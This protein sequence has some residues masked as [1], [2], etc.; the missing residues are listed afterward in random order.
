MQGDLQSIM[1][2]KISQTKKG[3]EVYDFIRM[4]DIKQKEG[5]KFIDMDNNFKKNKIIKN[6]FHKRSVF[7]QEDNKFR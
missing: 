4:W 3:H 2:S 1:L 5:N 6:K 7:Y